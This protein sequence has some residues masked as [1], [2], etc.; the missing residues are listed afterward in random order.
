MSKKN[1]K[2]SKRPGRADVQSDSEAEQIFSELEDMVSPLPEKKSGKDK[3]LERAEEARDEAK[4]P[5][6]VF[7]PEGEVHPPAGNRTGAVLPGAEGHKKANEEFLKK[8]GEAEEGGVDPVATP[9]GPSR[10][11]AGAGRPNRRKFSPSQADPAPTPPD[12]PDEAESEQAPAPPPPQPE[13]RPLR[14]GVALP[15]AGKAKKRLGG[16]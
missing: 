8:K 2:K 3:I 16:D 1:N 11:P 14:G 5:P 15:D 6:R 4:R 10:P 9:S 12:K 13:S 7:G